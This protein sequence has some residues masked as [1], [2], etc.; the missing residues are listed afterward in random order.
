MKRLG[1]G[2]DPDLVVVE[3]GHED[4]RASA[5]ELQAAVEKTV[6]RL[7]KA[8]P[9]A[10]VV[11]MGTTRAYPENQ[12]L[13]PLHRAIRP[14][15]GRRRPVRRPGGGGLDHRWRTRGR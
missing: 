3:G 9:D 4:Y 15:R 1:N 7:Q 2:P 11:L 8:F 6:E 5:G 10:Q 13:A 12:V 14:A